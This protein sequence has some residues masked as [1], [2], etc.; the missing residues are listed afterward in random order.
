MP[1]SVVGFSKSVMA[2]EAERAVGGRPSPRIFRPSL[3]ARR[4][5]DDAIGQLGPENSRDTAGTKHSPPRARRGAKG[6]K[7]VGFS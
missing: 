3:S 7:D 2:G 4:Y 5:K 6:L 1:E